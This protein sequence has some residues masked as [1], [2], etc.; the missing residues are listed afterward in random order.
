MTD[1]NDN[2]FTDAN[3]RLMKKR[4]QVYKLVRSLQKQFGCK[5]CQQ[6]KL[7]SSMDEVRSVMDAKPLSQDQTMFFAGVNNEIERQF[8]N[9]YVYIKSMKIPEI[10]GQL[11]TANVTEFAGIIGTIKNLIDNVTTKYIHLKAFVSGISMNVPRNAVQLNEKYAQLLNTLIE[12]EKKDAI[13]EI[14]IELN[15]ILST[16]EIPS[17]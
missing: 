9:I 6:A 5:R 8:D 1:T 17:E 16:L 3:S 14:Y 12:I 7:T 10:L 13:A 2:L 11:R 15:G 4:H